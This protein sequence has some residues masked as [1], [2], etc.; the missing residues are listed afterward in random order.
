MLEVLV[1]L[2]LSGLLV[3]ILAQV[4]GQALHN[5]RVLQSSLEHTTEMATFRRILHRDLQNIVLTTKPKITAESLSFETSNNF[6]SGAPLPVVVVWGVKGSRI[7]REESVQDMGYDSA[8]EMLTLTGPSRVEL[9]DP[10]LRTWVD[11]G[12]WALAPDRP[13]PLALRMTLRVGDGEVEIVER[14]YL[15]PQDQIS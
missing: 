12:T 3:A 14:M 15:G 2:M 13:S 7:V 5:N 11:L 6:L 1:S 4:M 10:K 8:M 9:L